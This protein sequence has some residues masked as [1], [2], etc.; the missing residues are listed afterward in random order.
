[1]MDANKLTGPNDESKTQ[2]FFS[3]FFKYILGLKIL[4]NVKLWNFHPNYCF[5]KIRRKEAKIEKREAKTAMS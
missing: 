1:M 3:P 2:I 4:F 5:A